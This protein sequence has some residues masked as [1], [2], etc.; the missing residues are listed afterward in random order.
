M[1]HGECDTIQRLNM[2]VSQTDILKCL[3]CILSTFFSTK[4]PSS[5][6]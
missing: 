4:Q 2:N 1:E 3:L 6:L 5:S